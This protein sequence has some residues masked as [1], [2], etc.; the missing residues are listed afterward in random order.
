MKGPVKEFVEKEAAR[1]R[2]GSRAVGI[3][4]LSQ[5]LRLALDH[6]IEARSDPEDMPYRLFSGKEIEI[7]L[8]I[9]QGNSVVPGEELLQIDAGPVPF[10]GPPRRSP[11]DYRWRESYSPSEKRGIWTDRGHLD[12]ALL[13]GQPFP[14]LK[15]RGL[16][17]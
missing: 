10:P 4:D 8:K 2:L 17:I 3:L 1:L 15:G 12:L 6:R 9:L 5:D 14:D 11:P 13:K 16:V 7:L